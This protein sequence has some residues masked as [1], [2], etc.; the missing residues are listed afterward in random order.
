MNN[1]RR[2]RINQ[3]ITDFDALIAEAGKI[4][5]KKDELLGSIEELRDEEQETYENMPEGLQASERGQ[6]AQQA[7]EALSSA[8]DELNDLEP[9]AEKL[10]EIKNY[11]ETAA[12]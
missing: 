7:S 8:Y 11:L 6:L 5:E 2:K 12:E 1:N 10:E 3:L 4:D 9:Y